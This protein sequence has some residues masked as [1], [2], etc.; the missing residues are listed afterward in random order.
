MKWVFRHLPDCQLDC[1]RAGKEGKVLYI[2][3][4]MCA[5]QDMRTCG[6]EHCCLGA[7]KSC[8]LNNC[9]NNYVFDKETLEGA[10]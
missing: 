6:N 10:V 7:I 5:Q 9:Q 1:L 8:K 4:R 3:S 2:N